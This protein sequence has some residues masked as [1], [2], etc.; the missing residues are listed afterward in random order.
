MQRIANRN[1]FVFENN[2]LTF[3]A[4]KDNKSKLHKDYNLCY[5][6]NSD[7]REEKINDIKLLGDD[8]Y[9]N[10]DVFG[11]NKDKFYVI[12]EI[13]QNDEYKKAMVVSDFNGNVEIIE[14]K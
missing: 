9:L 5:F 13:F 2:I 7:L 11:K 1:F 3:K 12:D 14:L 6:I 8:Y 4:A 10:I